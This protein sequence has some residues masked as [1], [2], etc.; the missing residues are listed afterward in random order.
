[1]TDAPHLSEAV[2]AV[3]MQR[4]GQADEVAALVSFLCSKDAAY[5]TRQVISI[6]GGLC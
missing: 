2:K 5:I 6:N 3:P 1:M 4:M